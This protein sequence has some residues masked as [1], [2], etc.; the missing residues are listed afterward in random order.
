[1]FDHEHGA[2]YACRNIKSP[3]IDKTGEL[4]FRRNI[5]TSCN[6]FAG[7]K[8]LSQ[9]AAVQKLN[10]SNGQGPKVNPRSEKFTNK[11]V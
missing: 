3:W 2:D 9:L 11:H 1:M 10:Q 6:F 4:F 5:L 8:A 7:K